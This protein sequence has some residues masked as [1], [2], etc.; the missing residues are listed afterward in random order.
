MQ[1]SPWANSC[2]VVAAS[3]VSQTSRAVCQFSASANRLTSSPWFSQTTTAG[4]RDRGQR[5]DEKGPGPDEPDQRGQPGEQPV[6]VEQAYAPVEEAERIAGLGLLL[7]GGESRRRAV[8]G[9][10]L[11]QRDEALLR[12]QVDEPVQVLLGERLAEALLERLA[13]LARRPLAVELES[14]KYSCSP[15]WKYAPERGSLTTYRSPLSTG[16]ISRSG[17]RNGKSAADECDH[18]TLRVTSAAH[19][20][21]QASGRRCERSST[22]RPP[23]ASSVYLSL[24][25]FVAGTSFGLLWPGAWAGLPDG[26]WPGGKLAFD[27]AIRSSSFY[28]PESVLFVSCA[29]PSVHS[30]LRNV[31]TDSP[32]HPGPVAVCPFSFRFFDSHRALEPVSRPQLRSLVVAWRCVPSRVQP[33][34]A[35][36]FT[37]WCVAA[38]VHRDD[39]W[40]DPL[41]QL[42]D[43]ESILGRDDFLTRFHGDPPQKW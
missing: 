39:G 38:A 6:G 20:R 21:C 16:R 43:P 18:E 26:N 22:R 8:C 29:V 35:I 25:G 27:G 34:D 5:H 1:V 10:L 33:W 28:D 3:R 14:R 13:D 9:F 2:R 37:V 23:R 32:G 15:S 7:A 30:C 24:L 17:R 42:D 31:I 12:G 41:L 36:G 40:G 4:D 11:G 19:G